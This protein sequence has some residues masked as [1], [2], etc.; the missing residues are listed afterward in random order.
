AERLLRFAHRGRC[1]YLSLQP[2]SLRIET[3]D[4][5]VERGSAQRAKRALPG[6][7]PPCGLRGVAKG[8]LRF[9]GVTFDRGE[10][11]R[12]MQLAGESL[13]PQQRLVLLRGLAQ[14]HEA[15]RHADEHVD[16]K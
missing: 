12:V 16:L 6:G 3:L 11:V 15:R 9:H 5:A 1:V 13:R 14:V 4:A 8:E 2:R 7:E 10:P